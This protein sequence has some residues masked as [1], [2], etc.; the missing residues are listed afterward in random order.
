MGN[1]GSSSSPV[2]VAS[3]GVSY[4]QNGSV[5][6]CV[7]CDIAA[8][9]VQPGKPGDPASFRELVFE[10]DKVVCFRPIKHAADLHFLVIPKQHE[11]NVNTIMYDSLALLDHMKVVG[12]QVLKDQQGAAAHST[13]AKAKNNQ[14][15]LQH[16]FSFHVP[17]YNSIDHLHLHCFQKPFKNL[18]EQLVFFEGTPWCSSF[19][20]LRKKLVGSKCEEG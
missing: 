18:K 5:F 13:T 2:I 17:P 15:S 11:Q 6:S 4:G 8:K 20:D 10:D 12:D 3:K 1:G 9:K 7:F 16:Q 14:E 19:T